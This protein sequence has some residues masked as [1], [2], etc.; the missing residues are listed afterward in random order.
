MSRSTRQCC[1]SA[2]KN[3]G[4]LRVAAASPQIRVADV[5]G[6]AEVALAAVRAAVERGVRAL[7]LPELNLCGYTAADLF[8]NR[9]LLHA[10]EAALVHI[11]DET[12]E[13][14]IVFTIGLPVA[15]AENIYNCAAVCCAG[16]LLGL[17]AKKYLPN[18]GEF[19]ERRWFAPAPA[20]PVWV[21]FAGQGPVPLGSELVYRCC[22]EGAED[23]VLGVEVCEDLWAPAP[24]STEMALAG[25][26][27]ILNP[28]ASDEIIGKADYRRSLISN[29]SARLYCA[30]AYA[31][32]SEGEST[33]D[34]VFAGENLVYENGSKLAATKLLTCDMTIADVDLDRLVAERRR[35]TTWT[36]T[37][38][39][40]ESATV[41][42]SFE[43]VLAEEPVLRDALDIDR[44]FPR[45][46]FVPADHGDLA[47]RCETILDL[48][49]AGLKTR[50]AHTGTKAA[51]IGLSGGLDSTL[52]LLVTVRAFDALG[53][54]RTGITAVSMP[55]F[56]TTHRTKSN[57]ESLARDLGVSFREVSIHAAVEQHFKDIEHDPAVQDV[58]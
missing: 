54:P 24:P 45:A 31:D 21:E 40:P 22:D 3:D 58:T 42:F 5:E 53:L 14:P 20:D 44:V 49:T 26:T 37:D 30:Y 2:N 33:T 34:M 57:A 17:T 38:D 47:E 32:A 23:M 46:P 19:Y 15:V 18:Y 36:R 7:V 6:N 9:T 12:R 10:C 11:L 13:L 4:F 48:Q 56:G 51:V 52:A 43:G 25:A 27:V 16:E 39:A 55:G 8:H 1:V 29:Q 41:E 35:S 50:L 28:S